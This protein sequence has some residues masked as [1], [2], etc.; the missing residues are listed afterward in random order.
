[1][2]RLLAPEALDRATTFVDRQA[3]PLERS[4]WAWSVGAADATAV[5]EALAAFRH[6]DGGFG[7]GLEPDIPAPGSSVYATTLA[8]QTLGELGTPA[9]DPLVAGAMAF[10][11]ER[12]DAAQGAWAM[13]PEDLDDAP[14]APWWEA[15]EDL[16]GRRVNPRA[17]ILGYGLR[18]PGTLPEPNL[19]TLLSETLDELD[20]RADEL[21]QHEL[22]CALRL[23]RAPGLAEPDRARLETVLWPVVQ[24]LVGRDGEAW[25]AYGLQP[26]WVAESPAAP[27]AGAL[28]GPIDDNLDW[29]IDTQ[30]PDG[31]WSPAWD[32]SFVDA[33]AWAKAKRAW[34]GIVTVKTLRALRAYRRLPM[35]G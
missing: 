31:A 32:W 34:Q 35:P 23:L 10:L 28:A 18:W 16:S 33:E 8:L 1:M 15:E 7:H 25:S 24:R 2:T 12:F 4:L 27:F 9:S 13:V 5:R 17:E 6:A 20:R 26:V 29:L 30:A 11:V 3:R 19:T 21:E 22:L 14:H